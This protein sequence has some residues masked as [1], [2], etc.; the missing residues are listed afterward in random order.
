MPTPFGR[1]NR[2]KA[3]NVGYTGYHTDTHSLTDAFS[4]DSPL[5][6]EFRSYT[7]TKLEDHKILDVPRIRPQP[8]LIKVLAGVRNFWAIDRTES[9]RR[10]YVD[11]WLTNLRMR[12][13]YVGPH[14][15]MAEETIAEGESLP[16]HGRMDYLICSIT[17]GKPDCAPSLIIEAKN[18][19]FV[20][21]YDGVGQLVA[22][23]DT[24]RTKKGYPYP[25]RGIVTNAQKWRFVEL[26]PRYD[27]VYL[28]RLYEVGD[29]RFDWPHRWGDTPQVC[30]WLMK[31]IRGM[32][33][34]SR[35]IAPKTQE[36]DWENEEEED[37]EDDDPDYKE[38]DEEY[39][40]EEDEEKD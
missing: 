34:T 1:M 26:E 12:S 13:G 36:E 35:F 9:S 16:G 31:F 7:F 10:V 3:S 38:E 33:N 19:L 39:D 4:F 5:D 6:H 22:E 15:I 30:G 14:K 24:V 40:D 25:L 21:R 8:E 37:R 17:N 32:E 11:A 27:E 18:L 29:P 20:N 2:T 23:M 28:T